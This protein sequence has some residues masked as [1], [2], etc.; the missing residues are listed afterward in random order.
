[1]FGQAFSSS[2]IAQC[3]MEFLILPV[4]T[5]GKCLG[6]AWKKRMA[7]ILPMELW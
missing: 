3:V 6:Y 2:E 7:V 1:M 5:A 4:G